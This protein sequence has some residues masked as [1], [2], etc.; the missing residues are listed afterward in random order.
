[1][2]WSAVGRIFVTVLAISAAR[3]C[4]TARADSLTN[5]YSP[6]LEDSTPAAGPDPAA[7]P[8]AAQNWESS[9]GAY[10]DEASP[11]IPPVASDEDIPLEPT[12]DSISSQPPAIAGA[13][14]QPTTLP[15][16]QAAESKGEWILVPLPNHIPELGWG[17]IGR[18]GYIF[19]LDPTDKVSPPS[20]AGAMGFYSQNE[21]WAAGLGSKLFLDEDRYRV[22]F[23]ML[24]GQINYSF[25]GTGTAAGNS[26]QSLPLSQEMTGGISEVLF[27]LW[28]GFY[29]GPKYIG[30]NMHISVD[31]SEANSPV[32]IPANQINTTFSGLGL[33]A[34]WD[35]RDSQFYPRKGYLADIDASFHDP[36]IGDNFAYQIYK[37]AYNRYISLA[38]NQVLAWRAMGQFEGG[39]VPFYALSQF[40]RGPDLRGYRIGQYQDRQMFAAQAEYRYEFTERFGAVVFAGAGEVAPS[41]GQFTFD[42]LLPAGG[43]GLRAVVAEKNHV[44]IRLDFAWGKDGGQY[45]LN[46][47]E[48]F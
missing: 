36:A 47:G 12:A 30:A 9:V 44:A 33:H 16:T 5:L 8:S 46:V 14:T 18:A 13:A 32:Q 23:V 17:V 7:Q 15:A 28:P 20:M 25:F 29:L 45:Y 41:L 3:I 27:R 26:G 43:F 39:N 1:M 11:L 42:D 6:P 31:A 10:V 24:H 48:A 37:L 4:A 22:T 34:Q 2:S 40:G 38:S 35:T 21:S 19:H